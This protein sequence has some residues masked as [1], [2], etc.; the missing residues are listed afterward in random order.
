MKSRLSY[1]GLL[2]VLLT[3]PAFA[4]VTEGTD[5]NDQQQ[6]E[7]GLQNGSLSAG[8]ASK[9]ESDQQAL[10]RAQANGA[11]QSRLQQLQNKDESQLNHLEDNSVHGDPNSVNNQRMQS[12]VQRDENQDNR[13]QNGINSGELTK[14]EA[15]RME[16][17]ESTVDRSEA[18]SHGRMTNARQQN[19]QGR[20][21]YQSRKIYNQKHNDQR[22]LRTPGAPGGPRPVNASRPA[23]AP[24][25]AGGGEHP[26]AAAQ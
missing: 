6:I 13:I 17:G 9:M 21:D 15:S 16:R 25:P 1:V 8:E 22:R 26:P 3:A 23:G 5:A 10:E 4:Q 24:R 14:G 12:D 20:E 18:N 7:Q 2:A 11:S 19:I